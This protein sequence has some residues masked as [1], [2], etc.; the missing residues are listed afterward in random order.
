MCLPDL[1]GGFC[2]FAVCRF[3][4]TAKLTGCCPFIDMLQSIPVIFF[5]RGFKIKA[6]PVILYGNIPTLWGGRTQYFYRAR[7]RMFH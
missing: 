5:H 1:Q 2:S 6:I 4:V 7:P 3:Y